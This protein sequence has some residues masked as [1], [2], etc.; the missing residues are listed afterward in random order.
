MMFDATSAAVQDFIKPYTDESIA[1]TPLRSL[2]TAMLNENG[3]DSEG[4]QIINDKDGVEWGQVMKSFYKSFVPGSAVSIMNLYDAETGKASTYD[5]SY[6]SPYYERIE[7][8]GFKWDK[9]DLEGGFK[10]LVKDYKVLDRQNYLDR[11]KITTTTES[12]REDY[13][14]TNAVKFQNS[15]DLYIAV[16]AAKRQLGTPVVLKVLKGEGFSPQDAI[17]MVRGEFKPEKVPENV[18]EKKINTIRK[19]RTFEEREEF[20]SVIKESGAD[21]TDLY[22]ALYALPLDNAGEYESTVDEEEEQYR[23]G[24]ATG[25]EVST[26]VPNAPIEP[27]ERINKLTGL[28]YNE[29]AGTAYMDQDDPMRRMNMAA[30]GKV[31]NQLRRNCK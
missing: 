22:K 24:L 6:R 4:R 26:P 15:Q 9:Q 29:G 1:S 30:G 12:S 7:Q 13:L 16:S 8:T 3:R 2:V 10:G 31:L 11:L 14:K 18:M 20:K 28:P 19:L 23:E 27:D 25:G 17:L 5:T 21:N